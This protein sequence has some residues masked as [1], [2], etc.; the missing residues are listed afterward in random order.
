MHRHPRAILYRPM[1]TGRKA[2]LESTIGA[3]IMSLTS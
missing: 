3:A 1:S 2:A